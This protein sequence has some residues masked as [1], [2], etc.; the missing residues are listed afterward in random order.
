MRVLPQALVEVMHGVHKAREFCLEFCPEIIE[1]TVAESL[2]ALT[3]GTRRTVYVIFCLLSAAFPVLCR[4]TI[5]SRGG[6]HMRGIFRTGK[7]TYSPIVL[8]S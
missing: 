7:C 1:G 8:A 2:R 6:V 5:V 3:H 4:G